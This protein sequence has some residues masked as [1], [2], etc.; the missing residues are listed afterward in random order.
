MSTALKSFSVIGPGLKILNS[1][2]VQWRTVDGLPPGVCP[3]S[4]I[5]EIRPLNCSCTSSADVAFGWP[6]IFAEVTAS[7]PAFLSNPSA[8]KWSGIRTPIVAEGDRISGR[9]GCRGTTSVKGPGQKRSARRRALAGT[10]TEIWE[11]SVTSPSK[12]G[13]AYPQ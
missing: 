9:D 5:R 10:W 8:I 7:G 12:T 11:K 6:E 4:I 13:I 2:C 1:V 3:P